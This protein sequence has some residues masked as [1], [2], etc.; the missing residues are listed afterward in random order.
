M[1]FAT[2]WSLWLHRNEL[3]FKQ[4][5]LYYDKVVELIKIR[6]WSWSNGRVKKGK[7]SFMDWFVNPL[8]CLQYAA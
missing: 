8:Q 2:I 7:L 3:L 4:G 1:W 6:V 5:N